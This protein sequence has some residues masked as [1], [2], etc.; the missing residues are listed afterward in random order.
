MHA[1]GQG[2]AQDHAQAAVWYRLAAQQGHAL[3]QYNLAQLYFD[4]NGVDRDLLLAH[5]WADLAA[6]HGH[7]DGATLRDASA[8]QLTDSDVALAQDI[9]RTCLEQDY[10]GCE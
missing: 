5:V 4:G 10:Q 7:A 9:A 6:A 2:F 8:G 1:A 3:A